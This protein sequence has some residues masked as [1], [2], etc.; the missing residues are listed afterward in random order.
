MR[1]IDTAAAVDVPVVDDLEVTA[2]SPSSG[3][4]RTD[5]VGGR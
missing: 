2:R 3:Q 5:G 4:P 1:A